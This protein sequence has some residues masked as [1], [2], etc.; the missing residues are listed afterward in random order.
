MKPFPRRLYAG[1]GDF[2]QDIRYIMQNR[3][4][5][6]IAMR[7]DIIS[8]KFRERLMLMVTEVNGCRYCSYY[9]AKEA[10]KAGI[11]DDE[12]AAL[13]EGNIPI[14]SNG[15]L[16]LKVVKKNRGTRYYIRHF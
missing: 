12:L 8:Y 6:K 5:L 16:I 9:H 10:L 7:G 11:S 2:W 13:M 1:F 14:D 3:Q 4:S 15:L